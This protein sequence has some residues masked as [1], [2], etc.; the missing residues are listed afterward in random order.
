[1]QWNEYII[2]ISSIPMCISCGEMVEVVKAIYSIERSAN[3]M[4]HVKSIGDKIRW[5]IKVEVG[6]PI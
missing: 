3:V 2:S 1:M 6:R 4:R 5:T